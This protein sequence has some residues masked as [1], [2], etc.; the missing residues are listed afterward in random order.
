MIRGGE[1]VIFSP[2]I[3]SEYRNTWGDKLDIDAPNSDLEIYIEK[4]HTHEKYLRDKSQWWANGNII[5]NVIESEQGGPTQWQRDHFLFQILDMLSETCL[6]RDVPD[7]EFFI[8]KRDYPHLKYN[9]DKGVV[10]PYGFIFN[11][12]DR[13]PED[14]IILE[15][16]HNYPTYA[17]ILS[18]YSSARFADVLFPSSEDWES[19]VG[20]IFPPSLIP[21]KDSDG[22]VG[23]QK[24]RD[25]FTKSNLE[26]FKVEWAEKVATAFFRGS[27]TGGGVTAETNQRLGIATLG[28]KWA[29]EKR[30]YSADDVPMLDAQITGANRRDK[31]ISRAPMTFI[32]PQDFNFSMG[33]HHMTP[34]YQQSRYKY[35]VYIEGHCAACRYAFMMMLGSVILKVE[36]SCVADQMWYFPL[37]KPFVDHVPVKS[38]LSDL[39]EK[40]KWCRDNDDKCREIASAAKDL[41]TKYISTAGIL[42]YMQMV[43]TEIARNYQRPAYW[44]ET[45]PAAMEPPYLHGAPQ[46]RD[47]C[48]EKGL[49]ATCQSSKDAKMKKRQMEEQAG[50]EEKLSKDQKKKR[51]WDKL[52]K[53]KKG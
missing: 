31:K 39:E 26:K 9:E 36:S 24:I 11:K 10:E 27:A 3:N 53:K 22:K 40:I 20:E 23:P 5:C 19:A 17:P 49:C 7:C 18:F 25:L 6:Q 14:D 1:V 43:F 12:D 50:R 4:K 15:G 47:S 13:V 2:F 30:G 8:N 41:Y 45:A 32:N 29:S 28:N 34:I 48:C 21:D 16:E 52:V 51:N 46:E 37:L 38:D 42:D 33:N 35:L 44:I